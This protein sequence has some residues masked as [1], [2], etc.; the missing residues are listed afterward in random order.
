M[1]QS[2]SSAA[3]SIKQVPALIRKLGA[4]L[5]PLNVDLG[6]GRYDLA[7]EYLAG[8][9]VKSEV[10]DPYNRTAAHNAAVQRWVVG[11]NGADTVTCCNVLN[12]ITEADARHL[13][14][15]AAKRFLARDGVAYFSVHEG[16]KRDREL[17]SRSTGKDKWQNFWPTKDYLGEVRRVFPKA[18]L[19]GK[20]IRAPA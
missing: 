10:F 16:S 8:L 14:I 20:I 11:A 6:G 7:V 2:F 12:V 18:T 13:V 17:G 4:K 5:G 3:T 9:N 1:A 19:Q 15:V